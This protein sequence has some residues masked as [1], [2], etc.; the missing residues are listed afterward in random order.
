[1]TQE[2]V[3]VNGRKPSHKDIADELRRR[4]RSGAVA[5]GSRMPTQAKLAEEFGVERGAVRQALATLAQEGLL[6]NVSRGSPP[7]VA[8]PGQDEEPQTTMV[9][10]A[11][12]L[13]DAFQA[14]RVTID[15]V[16]LTSET[17]MMGLSEPLRLIYD[18][19]IRPESITVRVLLPSSRINLA[20]PVPAGEPSEHA[21]AADEAVDEPVHSRW[22]AQRNAQGQVLRHNLRALRAS[23]GI[24]V[25]VEFRALPF[26]PAMKLYLLNGSEA[27]LAYYMV[28]KREEEID[29]E[30]IHMYDALGTQSL[31]FSFERSVGQ[32]DEAF[33][34]ESQKWFDALW[35]TIARTLTLS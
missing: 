13:I 23:H 30:K 14:E 5:A 10:L 35:N 2:S 33:V 31:L 16:C 27:L 15:A 34:D 28:T 26:T 4:I 6:V 29:S 11:P 7:E 25:K 3:A 22:L 32:S 1:M 9:G 19:R 18:G 17:L 24:D 20:F 12:R 8:L 21:A